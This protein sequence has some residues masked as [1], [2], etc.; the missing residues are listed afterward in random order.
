M[1]DDKFRRLLTSLYHAIRIAHG[2]L[3]QTECPHC[4]SPKQLPVLKLTSIMACSCSDCG[5][6]ALP[7]A[8]VVIPLDKEVIQTNDEAKIKEEI[9][10][11]MTAMFYSFSKRLVED[12]SERPE[13]I[14]LTDDIPNSL[15]D[16]FGKE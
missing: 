15:E 13:G 7:F 11:S 1:K 9:I 5:E 6:F 10:K 2:G 14:V 12:H 3:V 4:R 16:L 8:G